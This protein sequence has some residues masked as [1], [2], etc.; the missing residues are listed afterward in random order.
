MVDDPIIE[1]ERVKI[2]DAYWTPELKDSLM[3]DLVP[4]ILDLNLLLLLPAPYV[5]N[6]W[7]PWVRDC[8]GEYAVG[9]IVPY[10]GMK[11][12]WLDQDMKASMGK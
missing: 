10:N 5:Y 1:A 8:N 3:R 9:Y 11:W 6:V 4:H 12:Y 2:T 7:Q